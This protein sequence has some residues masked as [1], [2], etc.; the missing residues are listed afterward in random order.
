MDSGEPVRSE[1]AR[2]A[3]TAARERAKA[4]QDKMIERGHG[5]SGIHTWDSWFD[6]HHDRGFQFQQ[7][8]ETAATALEAALCT[9][10]PLSASLAEKAIAHACEMFHNAWFRD[11]RADAIVAEI[12]ADYELLKSESA[13]SASVVG[14]GDF[15][16]LNARFDTEVEIGGSTIT[17]ITAGVQRELISE[18]SRNPK[19][20]YQLSPRAFEELIADLFEGFGFDVELTAPTRDHGRD[21]I[22]L[23]HNPL[24]VKLLI[25]CK[26][27]GAQKKVSIQPV[28]RLFGVVKDENATKGILVTTAQGFTAPARDFLQRNRWVL[29]GRDYDA[30]V[31]WLHDHEQLKMRQMWGN[32]G[33]ISGRPSLTGGCS[34]RGRRGGIVLNRC[35]GSAA[36]ALLNGKALC[37][38]KWTPR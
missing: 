15:F 36:P 33:R 37:A 3:A 17:T 16:A 23:G 1:D 30:L 27:Y 6:G 2:R 5:S 19:L 31:A 12:V 10:A 25:E 38:Q 8:T 7:A 18:A 28:E 29:E 24:Q 20:L 22:A 35:A 14:Y 34:S 32:R 13:G 11:D 21:V 4:F 26:R 9:K